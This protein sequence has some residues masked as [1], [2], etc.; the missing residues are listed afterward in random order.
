[1]KRRT[2]EIYFISLALIMILLFV[3]QYNK[4][5]P[6]NW[7]ETYYGRSD[8]PF[9]MSVFDDVAASSLA[10]YSVENHTFYEMLHDSTRAVG[11][12]YLVTEY[13]LNSMTGVDPIL[14]MLE[15]GD[16]IM[17]CLRG[18]PYDLCDS[19]H[20]YTRFDDYYDFSQIIR[21]RRQYERDSIF[22]GVDSLAPEQV[23]SVYP[24]MHP[25]VLTEGAPSSYYDED[26][27]EV[28]R[29]FRCD[30]VEILV[31]DNQCQAL[32][33]RMFTGK[34]ELFLVT[35][36]LMFTNLGM[37]DSANAE[38]AFRLMSYLSDRPVIRLE[39]YNRYVQ[40]AERGAS[41][42]SFV[43]SEP[44]L[45]AALYLSLAAILLFMI[46]TARRRQRVI[47]VTEPP[48]NE[49]LRFIKLISGLYLRKKDFADLLTKKYAYFTAEVKRLT[50]IELP[51]KPDANDETN[52]SSWLSLAQ[53]LGCDYADIRQS[54]SKI[55]PLLE[56]NVIV[57]EKEFTYA[58]DIINKFF[59]LLYQK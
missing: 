48:A 51:L 4:P 23:Y 10:D 38:Y 54:I 41:P 59:I 37:L 16:R 31:R 6:F 57:N 39:G 8:Q 14:T 13:S 33:I 2:S 49:T 36:P 26:T 43:L 53:R 17:L 52:N 7:T 28:K 19:L 58:A 9:G 50:G 18:F 47:P 56:D 45:R 3:Y 1:M 20:F 29:H 55:A 22:F 35:T 32:V 27:A 25:A 42:L 24:Q 15:R 5:K 21:A 40:N 44:S 12:S 34:G 11:K 30:S 46:F